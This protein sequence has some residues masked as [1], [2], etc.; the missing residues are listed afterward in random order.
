MS[1]PY[2]I[3][4]NHWP[5]LTPAQQA[6]KD[7]ANRTYAPDQRVFEHIKASL[8]NE[9]ETAMTDQPDPIAAHAELERQA[10]ASRDVMLRALGRRPTAEPVRIPAPLPPSSPDAA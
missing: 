1:G 7:E 3:H 2:P 8:I 5:M 4:N 9:K 6:A 10:T